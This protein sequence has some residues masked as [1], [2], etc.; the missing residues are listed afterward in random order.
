MTTHGIDVSKHNGAIDWTRV[1]TSGKAGFAILRAGYGKTASQKDPRFEEYYRGAKSVGIPVGAY[2]YSYAVSP[3]EA[4]QEAAVCI[5][6]LK[7][8]QFDYPIYMDVEEKAQLALGKDKLSAIVSAFLSTLEAAGYWVGLYM[9]A[10]PLTDYI[11]PDL[12]KKYAIWVAHYGVT[13]PAYSGEYGMWQHSSTGSVSGISG[14]VD[15]D[16]CYK[17]YPAAI[18]QKGLNGYPKESAHPPAQTKQVTLT[19]DGET[20]TGTL[21]KK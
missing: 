4:K 20:W 21:T 18:K 5:E 12:R 19:I 9:S 7:G 2:W 6:V 13:K 8:K 1:K 16:E 17:D 3:E 14:A 11:T 10:S 15:L